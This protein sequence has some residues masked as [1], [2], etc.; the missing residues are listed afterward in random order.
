[1]YRYDDLPEHERIAREAASRATD[2]RLC[3]AIEAVTGGQLDCCGACGV[4]PDAHPELCQDPAVRLWADGS[5]DLES[6]LVE[7]MDT[8]YPGWR[9]ESPLDWGAGYLDAPED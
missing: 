1:M 4:S 3:E 7:W 6:R 5:P 9:D 2:T 8:H